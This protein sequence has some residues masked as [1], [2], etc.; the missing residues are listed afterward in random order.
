MQVTITLYDGVNIKDRFELPQ[1]V[2]LDAEVELAMKCLLST[3]LEP[4]EVF[5]SLYGS[6]TELKIS[7]SKNGDGR[8][9]TAG[10]NPHV[11]ADIRGE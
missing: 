10:S 9:F 5:E 2:A 6:R 3:S 11:I 1:N 8:T 4:Y 7:K